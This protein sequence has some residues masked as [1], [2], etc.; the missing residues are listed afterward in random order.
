MEK[1]SLLFTAR[2]LRDVIAFAELM[3]RHRIRVVLDVRGNPASDEDQ[4]QREHLEAAL[5]ERAI[6]YKILSSLA[7]IPS[8]LEEGRSCL[9]YAYAEQRDAIARPLA[10][11]LGVKLVDLPLV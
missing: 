1:A 11:G 10:E 5:R 2:T 3:E 7:R 4:E 9:L 8:D 6:G